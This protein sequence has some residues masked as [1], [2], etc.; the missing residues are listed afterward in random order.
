MSSLDWFGCV[1][2]LLSVSEHPGSPPTS[3][4]DPRFVD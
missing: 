2:V 4:N 3:K 1:G